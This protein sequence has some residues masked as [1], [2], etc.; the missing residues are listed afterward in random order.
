MPAAREITPLTFQAQV[1]ESAPDSKAE[2]IHRWRRM[3]CG[4]GYCTECG[5]FTVLATE[6]SDE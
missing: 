4:Y 3:E 5:L 6:G 1:T 2:C